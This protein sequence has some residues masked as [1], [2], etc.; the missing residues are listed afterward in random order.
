MVGGSSSSTFLLFRRGAGRASEAVDESIGVANDDETTAGDEVALIN[1]ARFMERSV[2]LFKDSTA[3]A[4]VAARAAL[5]AAGRTGFCCCTAGAFLVTVTSETA[6]VRTGLT[7][8]AGGTVG[9]LVMGCDGDPFCCIADAQIAATVVTFPPFPPR[10]ERMTY[11][12][13]GLSDA[14]G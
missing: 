12:T 6:G 3:G 2:T 14:G 8:F 1:L 10:A 4:V 9:C 7:T 13:S 11:R 5:A